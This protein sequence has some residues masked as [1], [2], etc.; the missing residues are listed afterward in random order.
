[1]VAEDEKDQSRGFKVEDRRRFSESGAPRAESVEAEP[2]PAASS[3]PHDVPEI[4]FGTFVIS[5][6]A[7]G[8]AH[9]GEMPHPVDGA[10]T[11][12]LAGA[13]QI[14]EILSMLRDK[15]RGNLDPEEQR[16]VEHALYE[17]RMKFVERVRQG[18]T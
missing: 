9:L 17:L 2:G 16:L 11:V 10:T 6:S 8:L 15:T 1:M 3:A 18:A 5:L 7:Q 12:D 14:I 13:R 4:S